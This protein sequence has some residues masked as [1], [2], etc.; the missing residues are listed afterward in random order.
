MKIKSKGSFKLLTI[1]MCL[2]LI[3]GVFG[4]CSSP[5]STSEETSSAPEKVIVLGDGEWASIEMANGILK[6]IIENG[7]GYK[8]DTFVAD[9]ETMQTKAEAGE[10]DIVAEWWMYDQARHD[11]AKAGGN[12]VDVRDAFVCTDGLWVPSYVIK[13]DP[14]KGIAAVAPDL[15][16][17][18]DLKKY[19]E[20]F[21][22][23]D[24]PAKGV[25]QLGVEGWTANPD[26]M[27][28]MSKYDLASV[29]N[30]KTVQSEADIPANV[31]AKIEKGEPIVFYDYMPAG[32]L[33]KY[34]FI[35]IEDPIWEANPAGTAMVAASG[36]LQNSA[37]DI[38]EMLTKYNID[39]PTRNK[40][41]AKI[42]ADGLSF[43]DAAVQF[44]KDN[45]DLWKP[46]VTED[47]AAKINAAL[48]Q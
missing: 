34:D 39:L 42:E 23:P 30:Y 7:Y 31:E 48:A 3:A 8:T 20:I 38:Y 1:I 26:M 21:K 27:A 16:T 17:M 44:L 14:A 32:L 15:K 2:L 45:P 40:E 5:Q 47:A 33:G 43:D 11:K 29:Y 6:Y 36:D 22:D 12:I 13:G 9:E 24:D 37:P 41:L 10:I 46:W 35:H 19:V 25:I 28:R 4:A 18:E